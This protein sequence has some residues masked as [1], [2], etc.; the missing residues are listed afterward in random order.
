MGLFIRFLC[1]VGHVLH[2]LPEGNAVF[3]VTSLENRLYVL[4]D[5]A[6]QQIEVYDTQSYRLLQR[7]TI[8]RFSSMNDIV[9]CPHS[10]CLYIA[11]SNK[12]C[13]HRVGLK[14]VWLSRPDVKQWPVGDVPAGLSVTG[15]AHSLLVTCDEA[16]KIKEFSADGKLVRELGLPQNVVSPWHSVQLAD[17]EFVVCH[18]RTA[19]DP[20]GLHRVCLI[21][22]DIH[23]V[24][25]FGGTQGCDTALMNMPAHMAVDRN[26]FIFVAD[27]NNGRVL[28]LSPALNFV[29]EVVTR[30]Q[31][32]WMPVR[33]FLDADRRRLYVSVNVKV[34]DFTAGRVAVLSV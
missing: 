10:R 28:L 9:S 6:S 18:G 8:P 16:R 27:H 25:S 30:D 4:R 5:K 23:V 1:A 32:Q 33:L 20:I 26:E 11:D 21:G 12:D 19:T 29:R 15:D 13:I 7:L 14:I 17:G 34:G 22:S 24:R 3:G 31:L 2:T